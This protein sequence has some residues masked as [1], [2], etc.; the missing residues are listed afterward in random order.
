MSRCAVVSSIGGDQGWALR[1]TD[2]NPLVLARTREET[3]GRPRPRRRG[4]GSALVSEASTNGPLPRTPTC[5]P[6]QAPRGAGADRLAPRG[7]G[8]RARPG[9]GGA[10]AQ[11][12]GHLSRHRG[13]HRVAEDDARVRAQAPGRA[14]LRHQLVRPDWTGRARRVALPGV[15]AGSAGSTDDWPCEVLVMVA[16]LLWYAQRPNLSAAWAWTAPEDQLIWR[17]GVSAGDQ[18]GPGASPSSGSSL[19]SAGPSI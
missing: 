8:S 3:S 16:T 10:H 6:G 7:V 19:G 14:H 17:R 15:R 2:C 11:L 5:H 18:P 12:R 13:H 9:R 1:V 4:L